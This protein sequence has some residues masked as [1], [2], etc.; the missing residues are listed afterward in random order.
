MVGAMVT[1]TGN[2][3]GVIGIK[4]IAGFIRGNEESGIIKLIHKP[5]VGAVVTHTGNH[6]GH[7][8]IK[9]IAGFTD[10]L[11]N[12]PPPISHVAADEKRS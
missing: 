5:M 1:H 4:N 6:W 9:N 11:I 7:I 2:H 12:C 8:G 10:T 3:W